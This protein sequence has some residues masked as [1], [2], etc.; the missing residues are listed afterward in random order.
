M[1]LILDTAFGLR[2]IATINNPFRRL[3][4]SKYSIYYMYV[5]VDI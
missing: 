5:Y 2:E 1:F 3:K 4:I